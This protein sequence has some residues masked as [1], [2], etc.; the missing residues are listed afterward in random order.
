[1]NLSATKHRI[2]IRGK[3]KPRLAIRSAQRIC[4]GKVAFLN[5]GGLK[6]IGRAVCGMNV[7]CTLV[8]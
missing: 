4:F 8:V 5:D 6:L 7:Y 1:M 3:D 2:H